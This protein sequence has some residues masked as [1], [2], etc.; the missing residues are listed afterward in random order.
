S[1]SALL[2]QPVARRIPV[3]GARRIPVSG[4]RSFSPGAFS[5][6]DWICEAADR[7]TTVSSL[8]LEE[9]RP[10]IKALEAIPTVAA[11]VQPLAE[12]LRLPPDVVRM[13]KVV[14]LVSYDKTIA[15]QCLRMANSPLFGRRNTETV[16]NAVMAL[17][18]KRVEAI[19]L[20]C[21]LN[22]VI[23]ADRWA[24]DPV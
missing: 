4:R 5:R 12:M 14:E 15:A 21:C 3:S 24:F 19:L 1:H 23:P 2:L 11:I 16:A 17:G 18:L 6:S 10:E 7:R 9:L 20:G 22:S 13:E 8:R